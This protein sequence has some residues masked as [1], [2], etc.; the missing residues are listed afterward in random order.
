VEDAGGPGPSAYYFPSKDAQGICDQVLS[1]IESQL[2]RLDQNATQKS[3]ELKDYFGNLLED[4]DFDIVPDISESVLVFCRPVAITDA[5][6]FRERT[7][8]VMQDTSSNKPLKVVSETGEWVSKLNDED[9]GRLKSNGIRLIVS[10]PNSC[11]GAGYH[12]RRARGI[13]DAL[14]DRYG[15]RL[16]FSTLPWDHNAH[17]MT[18]G[19]NTAIYIRREGKSP[20][21]SPVF[22]EGKDIEP[23]EAYFNRVWKRR[24]SGRGRTTLRGCCRRPM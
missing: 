15:C 10:D 12:R 16:V 14:K 22:L 11:P 18:I 7:Q 21:L 17:H 24:R 9:S 20:T 4:F 3:M 6:D 13:M 19:T 1:I 5:R 23:L 2:M 8:Q